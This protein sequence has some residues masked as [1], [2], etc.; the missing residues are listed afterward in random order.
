[1]VCMLGFGATDGA[2]P[3][4]VQCIMDDVFARKDQSVL[5]Y[6]PA[7][8]VGIFAFRGLM[9]FGQSYLNDYVGL[10]IINDVRNQ[11]NRHFQSL[12]LSFFY[13]HPT[14][15][16]LSRVNSDVFLLRYRDH[17]RVGVLYEGCVLAR[18]SNHRRFLEGLGSRFHRFLRISRVGAADHPLEQK[19]QTFYAA[20]PDQHRHADF[21]LTRK[22]SRQSHRESFWHGRVMKMSDSCAR[23]G[24]YSNNPCGR[25]G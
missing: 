4:L 21:A 8:V 24:S 11:L 9:N 2:I 14:G 23:I 22:H 1:M 17:R 25:A 6:L 10:R 20:R 13:R 3:F 7:L 16:L 15:T 12:S 18:G 19:D 5:T